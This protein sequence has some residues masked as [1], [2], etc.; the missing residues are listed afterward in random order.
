[1]F[2]HF[3]TRARHVVVLAQEHARELAH[4]WIGTEH[5]LLGLIDEG[6]GAAARVLRSYGLTGEGLKGQVEQLVGR[7]DT[8]TPNHIPFTVK[9][10]AALEQSLREAQAMKN[11]GIGTEHLLLG[12]LSE[13]EGVAGQILT[14]AKVV[15]A[16]ARQRLLKEIG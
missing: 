16:E 13:P 11:G 5:L 6:E 14:A 2:D 7:G 10:K 15:P 9:A 8:P 3:T 4:G 12:I 1:L